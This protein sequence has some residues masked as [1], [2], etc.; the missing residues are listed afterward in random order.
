MKGHALTSLIMSVVLEASTA[1][2]VTPTPAPVGRPC[3]Q[4]SHCVSSFCLDQTC[5]ESP[6]CP[7][8]RRCNITGAE[9]VCAQLVVGGRPC[10]KDTDCISGNCVNGIPPVCGPNKTPTRTSTPTPNLP[11]THCGAGERCGTGFFCEIKEH[12]CCDHAECPS[13]T[14]C[15]VLGKEGRCSVTVA[16]I[17]PPKPTPTLPPTPTR[18]AISTTCLTVEEIVAIVTNSLACPEH[19]SDPR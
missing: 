9:G 4:S 8:F 11:G 13:G 15:L 3:L 14:S 10:G 1:L 17:T 7:A 12:V 18:T 19:S 5:C 16:T 2:A 6:F